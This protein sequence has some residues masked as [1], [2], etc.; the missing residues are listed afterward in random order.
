MLCEGP[1]IT[2]AQR[3]RL[4]HVST[5]GR[6]HEKEIE[7][8]RVLVIDFIFWF[9]HSNPWPLDPWNPGGIVHHNQKLRRMNLLIE[10]TVF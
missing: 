10:Q 8:F 3:R 7:K 1:I 9:F 5:K 4:R 2:N 6:N